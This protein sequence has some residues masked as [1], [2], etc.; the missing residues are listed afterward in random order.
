MLL[1]VRDVGGGGVE[2]HCGDIDVAGLGDGVLERGAQGRDLGLDLGVEV[3]QGLVVEGHVDEELR[4]ERRQLLDVE[5]AIR[6]PDHR[7]LAQVQ[8][9][10]LVVEFAVGDLQLP[11]RAGDLEARVPQSRGGRALRHDHLGRAVEGDLLAPRVL[12]GERTGCGRIGGRAGSRPAAR[13]GGVAGGEYG[14]GG[15]PRKQGP[16]AER[17]VVSRAVEV[18]KANQQ[19][20]A[21]VGCLTRGWGL[22]T[23]SRRLTWNA[24]S[25]RR[26]RRRSRRKHPVWSA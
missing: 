18:R 3:P 20:P 19:Q 14:G 25:C 15:E 9:A 6:L 21:S 2:A 11:V 26:R 1:G 22:T 16:A 5:L 8:I 23:R 4:T 7:H 17:H 24:S 13:S 10:G 12:P